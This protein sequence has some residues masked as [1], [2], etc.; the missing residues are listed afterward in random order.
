MSYADKIKSIF[1]RYVISSIRK[2]GYGLPLSSL[3]LAVA[4]SYTGY[5]AKSN[6]MQF[7]GLIWFL[8]SVLHLER[9]T[10]RNI[11]EEK[12]EEINS[13]RH[14]LDAGITPGNPDVTEGLWKCECGTLNS[15]DN[16]NCSN[17][18]MNIGLQIR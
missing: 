14:R 12:D 13:L 4:F 10:V 17:C 2:A 16:S 9:A 5:Q 8:L 11:L 15:Y 3:L 18:A 6:N 1:K 7:M